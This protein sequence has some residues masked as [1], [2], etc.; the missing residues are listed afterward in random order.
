MAGAL[1]S[2][3]RSAARSWCRRQSRPRRRRCRPACS[4]WHW[5]PTRA[6]TRA[7]APQVGHV[8]LIGGA[9]GSLPGLPLSLTICIQPLQASVSRSKS[10]AFYFRLQAAAACMHACKHAHP[11]TRPPRRR[12]RT[13]ST[14]LLYT[15]HARASPPWRAGSA[16]PPSAVM[17]R[18]S[19]GAPTAIPSRLSP[20]GHAH[21]QASQLPPTSGSPA[22]SGDTR[23]GLLVQSSGQVA[24]GTPRGGPDGAGGAS[25]ESPLASSMSLSLRSEAPAQLAAGGRAPLCSLCCYCCCLRVALRHGGQQQAGGACM[26]HQSWQPPNEGCK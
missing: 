25:P 9:A 23:L 12:L 22:G 14:I 18:N 20:F 10:L 1:T 5:R 24:A 21:N 8:W 15:L 6:C 11:P 16:S 4:R 17:A 13:A 7:A 19:S 2:A 3:P 26:P